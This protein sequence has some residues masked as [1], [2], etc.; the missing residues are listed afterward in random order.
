MPQFEITLKNSKVKSYHFIAL[1]IIFFNIA[2]FI[3]LLFFDKFFYDAAVSFFLI[4]VYCLFRFYLAKKN[5][6]GFNM[7]EVAFFIL[8]GCWVGLQN[9][10]I[11]G[12]CLLMGILYHFSV[13]KIQFVVNN[14]FIKK[15]NF[16]SVEYQWSQMSNVMLR[17]GILTLDF[18]NNKLIQ[19][20]VDNETNISEIEFNEFAQQQLIK[21]SNSEENLKLNLF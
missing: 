3:Y 11:A 17:D 18:N 10:F 2:V 8:A 15:T 14:V 13:Q 7:D 4:V 21:Y 12:G 5:K 6:S 9:Y 19:L 16:P 20:E 1:L